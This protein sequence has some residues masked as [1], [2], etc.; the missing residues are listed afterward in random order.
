MKMTLGLIWQLILHYHVRASMKTG[1]SDNVPDSPRGLREE[2]LSWVRNEL[3]TVGLSLPIENFG[4]RQVISKYNKIATAQLIWLLIT[5]NN[6]IV[7]F[8]FITY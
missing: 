6:I 3:A 7:R 5:K 8:F 1:S 4:S 2:L